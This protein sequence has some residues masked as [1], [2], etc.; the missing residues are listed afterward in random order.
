MLY[1]AVVSMELLKEKASVKLSHCEKGTKYKLKNS[2]S[3]N[4]KKKKGPE[5]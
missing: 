5:I 4:G 3:L 2:P 1:Q